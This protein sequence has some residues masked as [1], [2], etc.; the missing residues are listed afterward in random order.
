MFVVQAP[1]QPWIGRTRQATER[2]S[3]RRIVRAP[4]RAQRLQQKTQKLRVAAGIAATRDASSRHGP[5]SSQQIMDLSTHYLGL[6]LAHPLML[7]PSPFVDGLDSVRRVEDAGIAAIV[8]HSLFEEQLEECAVAGAGHDPYFAIERADFALGPD[9]YLERVRAL[10]EV[11]HVPVIA[12]LNGSH[13]GRWLEYAR[14]LDQAGADAIE[15]NIYQFSADAGATAERLELEAVEM[16]RQI[17]AQTALP[18]AVKLAPFY[19][20]LANFV[21]KLE[22]AGAD[23]FVLF[24]RFCQPDIDLEK[25]EIV[26]Q[27]EL[28]SSAELMLRLRWLAIL[29]AR[30]SSTF[31]ASGGVHSAPDALKALMAGA[32]GVQVV[33]EILRRGPQRIPEMLRLITRWLESHGHASLHEV[34][35]CMNLN[36]CPSPSAYERVNH[37]R[38]LNACSRRQHE[39]EVVSSTVRAAA[40]KAN[41]T[42]A[43]DRA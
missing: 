33:S 9:D 38:I 14:A 18:L 8:M 23:G 5:C 21:A 26:H 32:H 31:A 42:H 1:C 6:K 12:S 22:R 15:L 28:S 20:S 29:S 40:E 37:L 17:K 3:P 35:G 34:Q 24:S 7:G 4:V 10:K 13:A 11:V 25:R 43:D 19:T 36:R 41:T 39:K 30:S 16:V 27:L 2:E